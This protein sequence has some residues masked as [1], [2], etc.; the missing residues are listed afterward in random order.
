[1][2]YFAIRHKATGLFMPAQMF[3]SASRGWSTW[4]PGDACGYGGYNK[5]PRLFESR[6]R[7]LRS[8]IAW[9]AGPWTAPMETDGDWESGY[10]QYQGTPCP[11][12]KKTR[13]RDDLE[14]VEVRVTLA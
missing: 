6:I 12:G 7:A 2:I 14:I 5:T 9:A 13:S 8:I 1:M 11:S 10:Y 3:R 4:V